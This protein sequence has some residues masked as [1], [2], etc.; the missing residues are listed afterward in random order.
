MATGG[1]FGWPK[2]TFDRISRHFRSIRNLQLFR[3]SW[4]MAAGG[5]FGCRKSLSI[6][7]LTI[8]YQ[9]ATFLGGNFLH[10]MA[11][12]G[13]F[14][15]P[16]ITFDRIYRH[17]RSIRNF[18]FDLFFQNGR[19]RPFLDSDFLPKSI[20]SFLYSMSV[21]TSNMKLISASLTKLCSAQAFSSYFHKMAAG[22]HFGFSDCL[23]NRSS[24]STLRS[25]MD[26]SNM[27]LIRALVSQLREAQALACGGGGRDGVQTKTIISP[28]I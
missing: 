17:F 15:W 1:H 6:V 3:I 27:N 10:K 22:G 9:Y 25:S 8:S 7:F 16:K 19:Q 18:F 5:H 2:I 11:A 20:G 4:K 21:A 23:Q 28:E 26:V 12:G 24:S 13:H 14:G